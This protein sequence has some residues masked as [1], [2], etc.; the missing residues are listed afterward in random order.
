MK[1]HCTY[2]HNSI[3]FVVYKKIWS[4][5]K[6]SCI[7]NLEWKSKASRSSLLPITS[8][9]NKLLENVSLGQNEFKVSI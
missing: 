3:P 7:F 9:Y 5:S 6:Y 4:D 8:P 2:K 1:A